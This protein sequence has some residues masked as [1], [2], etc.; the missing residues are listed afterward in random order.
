MK[1]YCA[2]VADERVARAVWEELQGCGISSSPLLI[3]DLFAATV[4]PTIEYSCTQKRDRVSTVNDF[5][6]EFREA[7]RQAVGSSRALQAPIDES[8]GRMVKMFIRSISSNAPF[9]DTSIERILE[10]EALALGGRTIELSQAESK[11]VDWRKELEDG[12]LRRDHP[13][14]C[15]ALVQLNGSGIA[16]FST[17]DE[18]I[19]Y[20]RSDANAPEI[21]I[22][23][24]SRIGSGE[25]QEHYRD[26]LGPFAELG[27]YAIPPD[28]ARLAIT[29]LALLSHS[30]SAS[31]AL[32]ASKIADA[33]LSVRFGSIERPA[34]RRARCLLV[35]SL[36][37]RLHHH[38]HQPKRLVPEVDVLREVILHLVPLCVSTFSKQR[39][40]T[41]LEIR[42]DGCLRSDRFR[43]ASV[44]SRNGHPL[45]EIAKI[46]STL[47]FFARKLH[48]LLDDAPSLTNANSP[49]ELNGFDARFLITLGAEPNWQ[50]AFNATIH[51]SVLANGCLSRQIH[52]RGNAIGGRVLDAGTFEPAEIARQIVDGFGQLDDEPHVDS[53][54]ESRW[55][56]T[57]LT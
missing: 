26:L 18:T 53:G 54:A 33:S 51:G 46:A 17:T 15:A 21:R 44:R 13:I 20:M 30:S 41:A 1:D 40:E 50:R 4:G 57:I 23:A 10:L 45:P 2:L 24:T 14:L 9:V 5:L 12:I 34:R 55:E 48:W 19:W 7:L 25:D 36:C 38:Q 37:D 22:D 39:F 42:R 27:A 49:L 56:G 6:R 35:I 31:R 28:P 11:W 43:F 29:D 52:I 3:A 32:I 16:G 8:R 47:D